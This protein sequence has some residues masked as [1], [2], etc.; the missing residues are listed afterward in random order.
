[1]ES[2]ET[3]SYKINFGNN[4]YKE[5]S[6]Y[7]Q[8]NKFSSII[9]IVDSNT[10]DLCL[11]ILVEKLGYKICLKVIKFDF[12]EMNK[13]INTC[14][15]IWNSM[16]SYGVDRN[17]LII[18]LGGGVV[19]DL[20]GFVSS[21]YKRGIKFVNIPTTL[22][23]MVDASIGGKTGIDFNE[24]K[25]QVGTIAFAEM[26][27]IDTDYL[28]SL[29]S[30]EF[31]S[32]IAEMFKHG[33]ISSKKYWKNLQKTNLTIDNDL[34]KLIFTSIQIKNSIVV[35]DPNEK[36]IRKSLNFGHTLGH[37]IESYSLKNNK[38]KALLHGEA[39][40]IGMVLEAYLAN[41]VSGL[42]IKEL[43]EIKEAFKRKF[44]LI[45]FD[46]KQIN[47]INE[48]LIHDKKNSHGNINFTLIKSIGKYVIDQQADEKLIIEAF[49]YYL[50]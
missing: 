43:E 2:I 26:I 1:M 40:A 37:A 46:K 41:K 27:I 23:A 11:P 35:L 22:L 19:T 42:S 48:L 18:N 31:N 12:G 47:S 24:A 50:K 30:K 14:C 32:G 34:E 45:E 17:S 39:I 8:D 15:D 9:T 7:I 25:N 4:A 5:L 20:G 16:T 38:L 33:L 49:D 28:K 36:N 3:T 21:T 10:L 13:N 29:P 6:T 44:D